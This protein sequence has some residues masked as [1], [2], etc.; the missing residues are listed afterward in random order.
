LHVASTRQ[1]TYFFPHTKR[2][3]KALDEFGTLE[4]YTGI[5]IHDRYGTYFTFNKCQHG[6]CCEHLLR[7]LKA[8]QMQWHLPWAKRLSEML[9]EAKR[10]KEAHRNHPPQTEI[11]RLLVLYDKEVEAA[12]KLTSQ[13]SLKKQARQKGLTMIKKLKKHKDNIMLFLSEPLVPFTN[14]QAE[15]DIRMVKLRQ[16]ISGGFRTMHGA[17]V[18]CRIRGYTSRR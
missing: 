8:L 16:K 12:E 7:D 3:R 11:K 9:M 4:N 13:M 2:G 14:N 18:M 1:L 17:E 15:R 10:I 6:L 5:S